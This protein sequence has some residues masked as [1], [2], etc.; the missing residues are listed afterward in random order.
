MYILQPSLSIKFPVLSLDQ[1][2]SCAP[3]SFVSKYGLDIFAR[4]L[5]PNYEVS[6]QSDCSRSKFACV[7]SDTCSRLADFWAPKLLLLVIDNVINTHGPSEG[8]QTLFFNPS[9]GCAQ[10][11]SLGTN[12]WLTEGQ[13]VGH[14]YIMAGS[15]CRLFVYF[16]TSFSTYLGS[17]GGDQ[18]VVDA[19]CSTHQTLDNI[20]F[21]QEVNH[22]LQCV[23]ECK[24]ACID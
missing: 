9:M 2:F 11:L 13:K 7:I 5:G 19:W 22:T 4:K 12:L 8:V 6:H 15:C 24:Q 18:A 17:T 20:H 14:F 23:C 1:F 21:S 10:K 16:C 3:C